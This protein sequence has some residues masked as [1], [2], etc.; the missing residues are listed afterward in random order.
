MSWIAPR[1]RDTIPNRH[2]GLRGIA[3][4]DAKILV[5]DHACA[6]FQPNLSVPRLLAVVDAVAVDATV[7]VVKMTVV[8][9]DTIAQVGWFVV[10]MEQ[11][12]AWC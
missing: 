5:T 11:R 12:L 10:S 9:S 1:P 2:P 3:F 6:P 4:A 8:V 7:C